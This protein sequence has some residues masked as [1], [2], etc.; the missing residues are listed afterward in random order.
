[1]YSCSYF[2]C[3]CFVA[4]VVVVVVVVD[5]DDVV[6]PKVFNT[7]IRSYIQGNGT[8]GKQLVNES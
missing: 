3:S 5:D 8:E 2:H 4:V 6:F 7:N 1:M